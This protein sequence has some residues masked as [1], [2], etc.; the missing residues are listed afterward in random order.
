MIEIKNAFNLNVIFKSKK[1]TTVKEAVIEALKSDANLS[2]A[3]LSGAN[4]SD[5]NLSG[6]NLSDAYLSGA[7][8]SGANLS[9]ANLSGA[10][11]SGAN[12]SDANLSDA[13]LSGAKNINKLLTTPLYML[14]DQPGKIRAYKVINSLGEG[15]YNGGI[16]YE[17][18]KTVK[19]DDVDTDENNQCGKGINLST[20][21]WC[22]KEM[23]EGYKIIICEFTAKDIVAIPV[24]SDGKFRVRQC[25]VVGE[26]K[27]NQ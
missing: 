20:L 23:K 15:I 18:G 2:D 8:L 24:G 12:L 22:L 10:N 1:A 26:K 5:A 14:L 21:D 17:I 11:L 13:N 6:A 27:V 19:T 3:N 7:N 16:K 4:L 25:K 9:G